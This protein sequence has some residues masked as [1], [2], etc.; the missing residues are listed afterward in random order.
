MLSSD[1]S[2]SSA[3][4]VNNLKRTMDQAAS[5]SGDPQGSTQTDAMK[6]ENALE[7]TGQLSR[8][9]SESPASDKPVW[10]L[11]SESLA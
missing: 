2:P 8:W 3:G 7:A 11:S 5:G 10:P 9:P 1:T 6:F 4:G